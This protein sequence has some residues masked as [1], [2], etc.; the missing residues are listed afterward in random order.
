MR[1]TIATLFRFRF[2]S[3][4]EQ[5]DKLLKLVT[6]KG[7]IIYMTII[8]VTNA[9]VRIMFVPPRRKEVYMTNRTP[10][11]RRQVS[12]FLLTVLQSILNQQQEMRLLDKAVADHIYLTVKDQAIRQGWI[13]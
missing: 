5:F 13:E 9:C 11:E 2:R 6:K 10:D 4:L 12:V 3:K 1:S 7:L 8:I